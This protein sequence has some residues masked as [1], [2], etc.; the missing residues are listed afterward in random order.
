MPNMNGDGSDADARWSFPG[1][2]DFPGVL[3]LP[4]AQASLRMRKRPM[5]SCSASGAWGKRSGLSPFGVS[6][7]RWYA[8]GTRLDEF[9]TLCKPTL[10]TSCRLWL[11][12]PTQMLRLGQ[13]ETTQRQPC[14]FA[15]HPEDPSQGDTSA[16]CASA[17]PPNASAARWC[18]ACGFCSPSRPTPRR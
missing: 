12:L 4:Y 6:A 5:Q 9:E 11:T 2:L 16:H 7:A 8:R 18:S 3:R 1:D 14:R 10:S 17:A 13:S 15:G